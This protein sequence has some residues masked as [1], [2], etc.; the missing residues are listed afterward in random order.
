MRQMA[1]LLIRHRQW[2]W[3]EARIQLATRQRLAQQLGDVAY[4]RGKRLGALSPGRI[5]MED[6]AILLQRRATACGVIDDSDRAARLERL[7]IAHGKHTRA[8]HLA[9]MDGE[10]AAAL[11]RSGRHHL[12]TI[13]AEDANRGAI[14][15]RE[16]RPHHTTR[17][18]RDSPT[19]WHIGQRR[20]HFVRW[21]IVPPRHI[22]R[23]RLRRAQAERIER[24][25]APREQPQPRPLIQPQHAPR[26]TE[27]SLVGE[28]TIEEHCAQRPLPSRTRARPLDLCA[29][30]LDE[31]A[32]AH[33]SGTHRLTRPAIQAL[34]HLLD[35][36]GVSQAHGAIGHRLNQPDAP[37]RRRGLAP[38][39]HI[40]GTGG[41][42]KATAYTLLQNVV[43]WLVW[44]G[45]ARDATLAATQ[46]ILCEIESLLLGS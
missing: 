43:A 10:R 41:Q 37:T 36:R 4:P 30:R 42:A 29:R 35:K 16:D 40:G 25:T 27:A 44:A 6:L 39:L 11:L 3:L 26:P 2:Q 34:I 33:A 32:I 46:H 24:A 19:R 5:L 20:I 23:Q 18:E 14:R 31:L 12:E 9:S 7:D 28:E 38:R 45:K 21:R 22:G 13:G 15:S 17:E 1:W 8:I